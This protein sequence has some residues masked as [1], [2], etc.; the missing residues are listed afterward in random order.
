MQNIEYIIIGDTKDFD[1]CLIC[2]CGPSK[3]HAN[4][5]LKRMNFIRQIMIY[6]LLTDIQIFESS[7]FQNQNVG[8][9]DIWI[10]NENNN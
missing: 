3:E 2:V 1:G 6:D 9:M 4:E 8:G 10:D 5:I 7:R